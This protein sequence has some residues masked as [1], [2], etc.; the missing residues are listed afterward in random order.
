MV[1]QLV[2]G[3]IVGGLTLLKLYWRRL[4]ALVRRR[5]RDDTLAD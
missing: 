1:L 4:K 5:S 2:L 3:G